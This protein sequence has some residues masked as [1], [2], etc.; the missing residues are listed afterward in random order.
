[1]REPQSGE[2]ESRSFAALSSQAEN[3]QEKPLRPG[4]SHSYDHDY[5]HLFL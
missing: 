3:N 1:M 2:H 5:S 4:Y